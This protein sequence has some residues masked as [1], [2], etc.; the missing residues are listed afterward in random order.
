MTWLGDRVMHPI[1]MRTS[2]LFC[3]ACAETARDDMALFT[4]TTDATLRIYLP[5]I[6]DPERLQLHA[7][8]DIF[9]SLPY[10]ALA[11]MVPRTE[12]SSPTSSILWLDHAATHAIVKDLIA[13]SASHED[14]H[15]RRLQDIK[16]GDWDMF[17]RILM[18]GSVV[19]SAV[20]VRSL[21][22]VHSH[23]N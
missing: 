19:V 4:V 18:D 17:L 14:A 21:I 8:L 20:A 11:A 22:L 23:L 9:G 1:G 5:V 3:C 2:L 6:D 15:V 13:N 10:P 7:S 16:D 12:L